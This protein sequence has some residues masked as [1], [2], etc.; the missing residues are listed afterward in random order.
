MTGEKIRFITS[1][2]IRNKLA[3]KRR[4]TIRRN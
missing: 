1:G 3:N 2:C 4:E